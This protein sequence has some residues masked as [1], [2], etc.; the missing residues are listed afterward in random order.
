MFT[1]PFEELK[2]IR[3]VFDERIK[4]YGQKFPI[5]EPQIVRIIICT[6]CM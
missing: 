5:P 2:K 1:K 6:M 3:Q 4:V